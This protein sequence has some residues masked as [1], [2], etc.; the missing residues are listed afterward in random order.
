MSIVVKPKSTRCVS[1]AAVIGRPT[2]ADW[3]DA[4]LCGRRSSWAGASAAAHSSD[5]WPGQTLLGQFQIRACIGSGAMGTVYEAW[6][7]GL[8]RRVAVKIMKPELRQDRALVARF[9]REARAVAQLSHPNIVT[10]FASGT[11]VDGSPFM[12]MEYVAGKPLAALLPDRGLPA[13]RVAGLVRQLAAGL[14]EAHAAGIVHRDLKP[15]NIAVTRRGGL[16]RVKIL[17]FGIAQ[18]R[19]EGEAAWSRLTQDGAVFGTPDYLAPEQ[20]MGGAVDHRADL[21]SLGVIMYRMGTGRM[22]F[23][24]NAVAVMLS[25]LQDEAPDPAQI[26]PEI[27]PVLAEVIRRC[28]DKDPARRFQAAADLADALASLDVGHR[29]SR[30]DLAVPDPLATTVWQPPAEPVA[31]PD[32]NVPSVASDSAV[33]ERPACRPPHWAAGRY[34]GLLVM[35]LAVIGLLFAARTEPSGLGVDGRRSLE[36]PV[37]AVGAAAAAVAETPGEPTP[38]DGERAPQP[39]GRRRAVVVAETGHAFEVM[40]P[41]P[42]VAAVD[43]DVQVSV[44]DPQGAP[45]RASAVTLTLEAPGGLERGLV[46]RRARRGVYRFQARFAE[47]GEHYLHIFSPDGD[48]YVKMWLDVE[49][50]AASVP[51]S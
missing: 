13:A 7:T 24:G 16:E 45:A 2:C 4:D 39:A 23:S 30:A 37:S 10:V 25:H 29:L 35:M 20:A 12:V 9:G 22:P 48:T 19:R 18:V 11:A 43:Y 49:P 44:W 34:G 47:A 5:P 26:A 6:Q 27:D 28:L 36:Q 33:A 42:L 38:A 14:G 41:E 51:S 50:G 1:I 21:Y 3:L 32:P 8:E 46:A 31:G 40:L 17:D 15:E